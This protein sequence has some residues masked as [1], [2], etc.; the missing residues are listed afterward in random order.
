M[1]F[2]LNASIWYR[3]V[4]NGPCTTR[5]N[6]TLS[7]QIPNPTRIKVKFPI[8]GWPFVSNFLLLGTTEGQM[9]RWEMSKSSAH[10]TRSRVI[11]YSVSNHGEYQMLNFQQHLANRILKFDV[12]DLEISIL[13]LQ[14][15]EL[16]GFDE[17]NVEISR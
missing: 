13:D 2:P 15:M 8:P 12:D 10:K 14:K 3:I 16:E 9:P 7:A 5:L 1:T 4:Y 17:R 11:Q 6:L